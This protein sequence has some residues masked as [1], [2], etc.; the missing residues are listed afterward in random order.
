MNKKE[1]ESKAN[2]FDVSDLTWNIEQTKSPNEIRFTIKS[3]NRFNN[4]KI[5]LAL[6]YMRE[7]LGAAIG[8][9]DEVEDKQ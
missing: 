8:I 4:L 1:L 6:S 9:S 5:W 3:K 2:H 7:K